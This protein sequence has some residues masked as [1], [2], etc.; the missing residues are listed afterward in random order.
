[1][2]AIVGGVRSGGL[3]VKVTVLPF[4]NTIQVY[5]GT[6]QP[7]PEGVNPVNLFINMGKLNY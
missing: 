5:T 3:L 1:M 4:T 2:A 7:N 6:R